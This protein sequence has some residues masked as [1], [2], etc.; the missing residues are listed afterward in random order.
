MFTFF[1][2]FKKDIAGSTITLAAISFPIILGMAGLGTD[3]GLWMAEKRKLQA[4]ADAAAMAA[5]WELMQETPEYMDTSALREALRNG[6]TNDGTMTLATRD[7]NE[8]VIVSANIRQDVEAYFS[9]L[10]FSNSVRVN[11]TAESLV[12]G[13]E[14]DFCVLSLDE[15]ASAAMTTQGSVEL[16]MP[17]CGIAVN[18]SHN[19]ALSIGGNVNINVDNIRIVGSHS[20]SGNSATLDYN[21]L[22]EGRDPLEDP[23]AELEVPEYNGCDESNTHLSADATLSPGVYCGGIQITGTNTV[24]FEPGVYILDRGDFNVSG[25]G[26]LI[27]EGVTFILTGNGPH[28]ASMD[29]TG[30]REINFS[31]PESGEDW[32]GIVF[33]Q[34][35]N[36]PANGTNK[37][38]GSNEIVMNGVAYFPA[39]NLQFGGGASFFGTDDVCTRL[40]GKTVTLSGNPLLG[41]NC[42]RYDVEDPVIPTVR[43]IR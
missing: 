41:N 18:S 31:A 37:L 21:Y 36:A 30:G 11:I 3:A 22:R 40:I 13:V 16:Q 6:Y 33:F 15:S 34:D 14:G 7:S 10:V 24:E 43:L 28:Y 35:P 5:G 8:G 9:K 23:Y 27:G 1:S 42:E 38:T 20:V 26:A 32:A 19:N 25:N 39:Q 2:S 4:A 29:I 17:S 12:T